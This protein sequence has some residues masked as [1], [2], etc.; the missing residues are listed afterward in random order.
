MIQYYQALSKVIVKDKSITLEDIYWF[1]LL[2]K[3]LREDREEHKE[4]LFKIIKLCE[5]HEEG[6]VGFKISPT[7]TQKKP[8]IWSTYFAISSMKLLGMLSQYLMSKGQDHVRRELKRFILSHKKGDIFLHCRDKDCPIEKTEHHSITFYYVIELLFLIE[9]DVRAQKSSFL[10][11]LEDRKKHELIVYRLMCLKYLDMDMEVS[12]KELEY[13]HEFQKEDGGYHFDSDTNKGDIET[14]F[15]IVNVLEAYAWMMDYNPFGVYSFISLKLNQF[16]AGIVEPNQSLLKEITQLLITL[17]IIWSKFIAEIERIIFRQLESNQYLDI[18][19]LKTSFGLTGPIEEIISYINL[20]YTFTLKVVDNKIEFAQF[21]RNLEAEKKEILNKFYDELYDKSIVSISKIYKK[22]EKKHKDLDFKVKEINSLIEEMMNKNIFKGKI[23]KKRFKRKYNFYLDFLLEKIIVCDSEINTERLYEEKEKLKDIKNDIYNMT[24]SLKNTTLKIREEIESYLFLNEI[25][26]AKERLKY[27]LRNALMDADFL[28]ENIENSFNQDLYYINIQAVLRNEI[29]QWK[30]AYSVLSNRL[31]DIDRYLKE[32]ISEKEDL[33]T[34]GKGLEEVEEKIFKFSDTINKKISDFRKYLRETLEK[35]Y[36]DNKFYLIT[37]EFEK[38]KKHVESFDTSIYKISQNITSKEERINKKHKQVIENWVSIKSE[39]MEVFEYYTEGFQFF[40]ETRNSIKSLEE[41]INTTIE[42]ISNISQEKINN[43]LFQE[44]FEIIKEES[45]DLIKE[46]SKEIKNLQKIVKKEI[47]KKQKLFLLF[48]YLQDELDELDENTIKRIATQVQSLKKNVIEERNR[49]Q[50]KEFDDFVSQE[51]SKLKQELEN[52]K[53][54]LESREN[55][56]VKEISEDFDSLKEKFEESQKEFS[57]KLDQC[58]DLIEDF[59]T[60][61]KVTILQWD[62]FKDY[63]D[64]EV[65]DAENEYINKAITEQINVLA[66]EKKRNNIQISEL[67]KELRLKCNVIMDRIK[68]MINISKLN[69]ELYEDEKCVLV[70]TD[71]YYKNRE[72][73]N[74]VDNKLMKKTNEA[75]GKILALYDSSV[76][77][78]TLSVNMLQLQN[79]IAEIINFEKPLKKEFES[80]IEAI[81]INRERKEFV[82]TKEHFDT[83]IQKNKDTLRLMNENLILFN[84]LHN[85]INQ[86]YNKL[87]LI[88]SKKFTKISELIEK[89]ETYTKIQEHFGNQIER[90]QEDIKETREFIEEKLKNNLKES[91]ETERLTQK[92]ESMP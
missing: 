14:T 2:R 58:E 4:E 18:N 57:K 5:M 83:F 71:D 52:T 40:K 88:V 87:Q 72:L 6:E 19:Q 51:I 43:N 45:D 77:N 75:I 69:A 7:S 39:L 29:S 25:S 61:S 62:K 85:I 41:E 23:V 44:A 79:R 70:Y 8:D 17:S 80:R 28:N 78:K 42:K 56:K 20:N 73:R 36:T 3:Y 86:E 59:D 84:K 27:V 81:Q 26:Y 46:I 82:E 15:W 21:I 1:L 31:K 53:N 50:I 91:E 67:K 11:F 38:I 47:K 64:N 49:S 24:L 33:I 60:K 22:F 37:E 48:K 55:L 32:K 76:R 90:I 35:E 54:I 92:L 30:K 65:Q 68:E 10:S 13:L 63:F 9:V 89:K 74:F 12:E 16:F 66:S 34:I